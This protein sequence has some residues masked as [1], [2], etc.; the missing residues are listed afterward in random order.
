M[1]DCI[2]IG[3]LGAGTV[4]SGVLIVLEENA[5]EIEKKVGVPTRLLK[6]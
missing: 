3:L 5:V 4:G 1:K 2:K 6:F